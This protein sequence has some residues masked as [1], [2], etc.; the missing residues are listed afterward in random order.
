[1]ISIKDQNSLV[2]ENQRLVYYYAQKYRHLSWYEDIVQEGKIGLVKAVR[3]F[4]PV[5][6]GGNFSVYAGRCIT[7]EIKHYIR[8]KIDVIRSPRTQDPI[9]VCSLNVK[10]GEDGNDELLNLIP[11]DREASR[12]PRDSQADLLAQFAIYLEGPDRAVME[13]I[14]DNYSVS[15]IAF[16]LN[17]TGHYVGAIKKRICRLARRYFQADDTNQHLAQ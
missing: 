16:T 15:Q 10:I 14:L 9:S 6:A 13:M 2:L 11:C 8:D 12:S 7:G 5:K 17:T 3:N 4:D 1:M